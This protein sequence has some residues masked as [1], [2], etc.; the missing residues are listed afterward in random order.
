M[1]YLRFF[2]QVVCCS[3]YTRFL[4]SDTTTGQ[5]H[6]YPAKIG[7]IISD[8]ANYSTIENIFEKINSKDKELFQM[9][10][11]DL[12]T[13]DLA[14][15]TK[16]S[17]RFP[18]MTGVYNQK[19]D[20]FENAH[21]VFYNNNFPHLKPLVKVLDEIG[22]KAV[23]LD[24]KSLEEPEMLTILHEFNKSGVH[25]I[26]CVID[27]NGE[28][29]PGKHI[30]NICSVNGALTMLSILNLPIEPIDHSSEV[31]VSHA[32]TAFPKIIPNFEL[33][34]EAID[35][36][37]YFNGKLFIGS[38]GEVK[39]SEKSKKIYGYI[40]DVNI[41]HKLNKR[42]DLKKFW[43]I[44]KNIIDIC[45]DCEFRYFCVDDRRPRA[46][47]NGTFFFEEECRFNPYISK[48]S[49]ESGHVSIIETGVNV[50]ETETLIND[51]RV[52]EINMQV[53]K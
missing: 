12:V 17:D 23:K 31:L 47:K 13:N 21:V 16:K 4:V 49:N 28:I 40:Q 29:N 42:N 2:S 39:M 11:N 19:I 46:R 35:R 36:N 18:S 34:S 14:F 33:Y 6:F 50:T 5:M 51:E 30:D 41:V 27:L 8:E 43:G 48:W 25:S 52:V 45:K 37:P 22:V 3:G 53:W 10:I 15:I 20:D 26:E 32:L 1:N 38:C 24:F 44:S 9:V 7:K